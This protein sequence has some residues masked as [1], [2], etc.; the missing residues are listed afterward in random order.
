M[1]VYMPFSA[2]IKYYQDADALVH[3]QQCGEPYYYVEQGV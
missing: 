1:K 2:I 3:F